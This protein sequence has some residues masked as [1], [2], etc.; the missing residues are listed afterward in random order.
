[1]SKCNLRV[2]KRALGAGAALGM[3]AALVSAAACEPAATTAKAPATRTFGSAI[4]ASVPYQP[5]AKICVKTNSY[6]KPGPIALRNLLLATYG[7]N[8]GGKMV[9]SGITRPCDGTVSEHAEG[10]ALD[11]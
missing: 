4:E 7:T 2:R 6:D 9:F 10:R 3:A 1:M 11:W 8:V 5:A